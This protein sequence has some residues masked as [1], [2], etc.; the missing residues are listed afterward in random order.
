MKQRILAFLLAMVMVLALAACAKTP[1]ADT[2]TPAEDNNVQEPA[3][4]D[5]PAD[6]T[7]PADTDE[8][9]EPADDTTTD[10]NDPWGGLQFPLTTEGDT[11]RFFR[12][13]TTALTYFYDSLDEVPQ[14]IEAEKRTGVHIDWE[15]VSDFDTQFPPDDCLRRLGRL[16]LF[17]D[18]GR[19]PGHLCRG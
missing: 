10:E 7:E 12:G 17:L 5:E 1:A 16:R 3:D 15:V 9:A 8:P 4:T 19:R 18:Q 11:Y 2:N 13:T 14:F 6:T